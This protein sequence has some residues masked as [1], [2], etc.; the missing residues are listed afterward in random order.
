LHVI[1]PGVV[2]TVEEPDEPEKKSWI[3][4]LEAWLTQKG[5]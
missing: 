2:F 3:D 1:E 4:R 5:D